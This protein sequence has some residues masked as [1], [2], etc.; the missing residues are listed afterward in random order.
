MES[1]TTEQQGSGVSP[2]DTV[3][4]IAALLL[5]AGGLWAF[6]QFA[7]QYNALIRTVM[8]LGG[9]V[10]AA[11]IAY[12]TQ[13]GKLTWATIGGARTEVRKVVWPTRQESMQATLMIAVI[14]VIFAILLG[15]IDWLLNMGVMA[16]T[17]RGN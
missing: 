9:I 4:L 10:G 11:A 2:K 8:L 14:V 5:L 3:L 15:I 7:G 13:M 16:L 12:Q 6:Y 1:Q 17:G